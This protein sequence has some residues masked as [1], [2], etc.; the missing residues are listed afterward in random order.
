MPQKITAA[1]AAAAD[2][3][4]AVTD[5]ARAYRTA[6]DEAAATLTSDASAQRDVNLDALITSEAHWA[7]WGRIPQIVRRLPTPPLEQNPDLSGVPDQQI[8]Q[9]ARTMRAQALYRLTT[10][11]RDALTPIGSVWQQ[12]HR[13]AAVRAHDSLRLIDLIQEHGF[14]QTVHVMTGLP[15]SGKSTFARKLVV[16]SG[17]RIRR[18]NLDD[19]RA[20]LGY[21]SAWSTAHEHAAL[22]IQDAAVRTT[23]DAGFDLAV[24]NTHLTPRIPGRLKAVAAGRATFVVHDL[25]DL[26]VH[27]CIR[28]DAARANPV[29]EAVIQRMADTHAQATKNGWR[30]TADWLN[31]QVSPAPYIADL[32]LPSAVMCDIDGTLALMHGRGPYDLALCGEDRLNEPVRNALTAFRDVNGGRIVLLSGRSEDFR[33]QT[34]AWLDRHAAY[35]ELHMRASGDVRRDDIVKN[36]LFDAHVRHRYNVRVSLDDRDRDRDRDRVVALWRRMGIPTWQVNYGNF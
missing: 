33:A 11:E 34:E 18:V 22:D 30:L 36:E 19:L 13:A 28:R 10:A 5:R 1:S 12:A 23:L 4:T 20:M 9:A 7:T 31:D 14:M 25:T 21:D 17:G 35:D 2:I 15:A 26:P 3:R 29:G 27:E 24:D 16:G 32:S 8:L 6:R